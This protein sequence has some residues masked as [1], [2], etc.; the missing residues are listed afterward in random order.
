MP[1]YSFTAP[2]VTPEMEQVERDNVPEHV[3]YEIQSDLY[4]WGDMVKKWGPGCGGCTNLKASL[5]KLP[6][7]PDGA[8]DQLHIELHRLPLIQSQDYFHAKEK[9]PDL[10]EQESAA[11]NFL[12]CEKFDCEVGTFHVHCVR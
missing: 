2:H 12:R 8:V 11:E 9:V 10:V 5:H 6:P 3:W 4:G 1:A 7:I